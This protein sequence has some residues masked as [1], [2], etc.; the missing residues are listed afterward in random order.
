MGAGTAKVDAVARS[1]L[2][3]EISVEGTAPASIFAL[4]APEFG[5]EDAAEGA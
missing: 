1:L 5:E 2:I 4:K 3:W